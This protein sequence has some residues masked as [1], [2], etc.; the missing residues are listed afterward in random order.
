MIELNVE[1]SFISM[2]FTYSIKKSRKAEEKP[3]ILEVENSIWFPK[4]PF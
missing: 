1:K 4:E 2:Q 3:H